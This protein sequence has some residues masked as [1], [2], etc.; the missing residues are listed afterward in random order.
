MVE[1]LDWFKDNWEFVAM[2]IPVIF[3]QVAAVTGTPKIVRKV[4][5][6]YKA[7]NLLSGNWGRQKSVDEKIEE[8]IR[9][10]K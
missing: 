8:L 6:V 2:V 3:P 5:I 9:A 4:N 1:T 7:W 10:A